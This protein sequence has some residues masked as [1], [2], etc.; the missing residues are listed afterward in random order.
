[1]YPAGYYLFLF[2]FD[3]RLFLS[4]FGGILILVQCFIIIERRGLISDNKREYLNAQA[5]QTFQCFLVCSTKTWP[6]I[7]LCCE[8][9]TQ[10]NPFST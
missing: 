1:M 3:Q 5:I 6:W 9:Y 2:T 7:L 10:A 8:I 4:K